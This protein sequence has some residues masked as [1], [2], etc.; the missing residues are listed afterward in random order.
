[1]KNIIIFASG[2]GSNAKEI[3]KYSLE[4]KTYN[5]AAIFCNNQNAGII[6]YCVDEDVP[7]VLFTNKELLMETFLDE[8]VSYSPSLIVLA[9]FLKKIPE[10]LINAFHDKIINIHPA[11]LPKYGGA[12][13][14]G[15]YIHEAVVAN[16][17]TETGITIHYVNANYDEGKI[18]LQATTKIEASDDAIDVAHKVLKLEHEHYKLVVEQLVAG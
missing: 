15:H 6:D 2:N 3:H 8:I 10:Y 12:G 7:C 11:L 13:M 1:M 5:V 14:Y 18:I 17:E 4:K 16:N 9:G